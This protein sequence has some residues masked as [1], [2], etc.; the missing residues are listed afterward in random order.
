MNYLRE[1][2]KLE[3]ANKLT[4]LVWGFSMG[5]ILVLSVYA[6]SYK[7]YSNIWN[8]FLELKWPSEG[9]VSSIIGIYAS[10]FCIAIP[11]SINSVFNEFDK[12]GVQK[13]LLLKN[14][15][16]FI[17]QISVIPLFLVYCLISS[18]VNIT[19]GITMIF[20]LLFICYSIYKLYRYYLLVVAIVVNTQE[21]IRITEKDNI[22][23]ILDEDGE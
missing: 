15:P 19:N 18:F 14:E 23:R 9:F 16:E 22:N 8:K 4:F 2:Y 10:V 12:Y 1:I 11:L 3:R 6:E 21:Y 5:L 20:I 17:F 13:R 7:T